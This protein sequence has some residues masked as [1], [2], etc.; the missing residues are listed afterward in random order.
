[1]TISKAPVGVLGGTFDP[2]HNGHLRLAMEL[3]AQLALHQVRLIPNGQPPHRGMPGAPPGQRAKWI[4]VAVARE[5]R[6]CLDDRE[7][8]RDGPSYMTDTLASLKADLPD[9]PLCLVMGRDVFAQLPQWHEWQRLFELAHIVLINRPEVT[10]ELQP[11]AQAELEQR[12]THDIQALHTHDAGLIYG[13]EP[14]PLAISASRIRTL[15]ANGHS[16]RYLL[17]DA[18]LDDIM[19]AGV[20]QCPE[21]SQQLS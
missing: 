8:L 7:L 18:I 21:N 9:Q 12:Q 3:A 16:P 4:R 17:P 10:T 2:I 13:Y 11:Q 5:P 19:D 6:L 15:L 20:Y 14:P 1:M